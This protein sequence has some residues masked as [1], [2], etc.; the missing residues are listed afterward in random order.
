ME[1]KSVD[2]L[3]RITIP[4]S[5]R[6]KLYITE[7]T[8][9]SFTV[10]E[11]KIILNKVSKLTSNN[12]LELLVKT[13]NKLLNKDIIIYDLN[14]VIATNIKNDHLIVNKKINQEINK[15]NKI[16]LPQYQLF[17]EKEDIYLIPLIKNSYLYGAVI[18][19]TSEIN[20]EQRNLVELIINS[21]IA[22]NL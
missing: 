6:K 2:K 19:K 15:R 10:E 12:N 18:I 9:L 20:S 3:G 11:N 1:I 8:M 5:I 13:L 14:K 21:Y 16:L 4:I 22:S 7:N 17:K